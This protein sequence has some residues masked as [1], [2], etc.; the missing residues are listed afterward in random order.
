M[1]VNLHANATTTPKTRAY[2]QSSDKTVIELS[3]ELG[4]NPSTIYRWR[5]REN[6]NGSFSYSS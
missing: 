2:I 5:K 6:G 4:V 3:K 1:Q